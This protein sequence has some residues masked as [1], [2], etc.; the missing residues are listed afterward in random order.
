[1]TD[2]NKVQ[3]KDRKILFLFSLTVFTGFYLL[4]LNRYDSYIL[5]RFFCSCLSTFM[6][7]FL[8]DKIFKYSERS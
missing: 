4:F 2:I 1:M 7:W 8:D 3:F 5:S 6:I